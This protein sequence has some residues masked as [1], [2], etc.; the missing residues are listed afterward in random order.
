M[1]EEEAWGRLPGYPLVRRRTSLPAL[2]LL[3]C[4]YLQDPQGI[5]LQR[6]LAPIYCYV[7]NDFC[8][9]QDAHSELP[10]GNCDLRERR[11]RP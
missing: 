10:I 11:E 8:Q 2:W 6:L 3:G 5:P 7:G 4:L 9:P 1:S